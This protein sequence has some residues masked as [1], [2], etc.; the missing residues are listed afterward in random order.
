MS[1]FSQFNWGG[2][3]D[4]DFGPVIN[5]VDEFDRHFSRRHRFVNCF[6]PRFD[7]EEDSH[8]YYLYGEV[9]GARV[10]DINIEAHDNHTLVIEGVTKRLGPPLPPH[11]QQGQQ[12]EYHGGQYAYQGEQQYPPPPPGPPYPT[13][14][15]VEPSLGEE[16]GFVKVAHEKPDHNRGSDNEQAIASTPPQSSQTQLQQQPT[17]QTFPPPPQVPAPITEGHPHHTRHRTSF[18][19]PAHHSFQPSSQPA[20]PTP[21]HDRRVLLSERLTGDFHRTFAFPQQIVEDGI[22]A[23]VDNGVLYLQVPKRE[24][25]EVK[26]GRRIPV[27][28]KGREVGSG[29]GF[30]SGAV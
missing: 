24:K 21:G 10:E 23:S 8:F 2:G 28:T 13:T 29:F 25:N 30:A 27:R 9:P 17:P 20:P 1:P 5:F 6:I 15:Q 22:E 7:L 3:I 12:G 16:G 26:R 11:S 19:T 14:Q 4:R 18:G